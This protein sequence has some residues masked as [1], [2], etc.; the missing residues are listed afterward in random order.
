MRSAILILCPPTKPA[1]R[2]QGYISFPYCCTVLCLSAS[3]ASMTPC[4]S[5]AHTLCMPASP[6]SKKVLTSVHLQMFKL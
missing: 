4:L 3:I 6:L 2:P 5:L 1:V